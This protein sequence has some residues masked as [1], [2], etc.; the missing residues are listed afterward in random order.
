[1]SWSAKTDEFIKLLRIGWAHSGK[2][3]APHGVEFTAKIF[4]I[5][6]SEKLGWKR[7]AA[8]LRKEKGSHLR[9]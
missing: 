5:S 7:S 9:G 6:I 8:K 2:S 4:G 3:S 1:M